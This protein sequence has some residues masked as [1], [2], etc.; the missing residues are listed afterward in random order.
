MDQLST[1]SNFDIDLL[2]N[3]EFPTATATSSYTNNQA[4]PSDLV[5]M[6]WHSMTFSTYD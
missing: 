4:S 5:P 1:E 6:V 3:F 2:L